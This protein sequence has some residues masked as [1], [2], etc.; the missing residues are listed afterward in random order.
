MSGGPVS[1]KKFKEDI[2]ST[3]GISFFQRYF[4]H[5]LDMSAIGAMTDEVFKNPN[6]VK[7]S[8]KFCPAPG[9]THYEMVTITVLLPGLEIPIHYDVPY[10]KHVSRMTTP[11]WLLIALKQSGLWVRFC[12]LFCDSLSSLLFQFYQADRNNLCKT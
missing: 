12:M 2:L 11:V 4:S 5:D 6:Y 8:K 1:H 7:I 10:F 9:I 3:V